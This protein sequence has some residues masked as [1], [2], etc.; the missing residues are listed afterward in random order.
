MATWII[1]T[2]VI[3]AM[4]LAGYKAYKRHKEGGCSGCSGCPRSG[5]CHK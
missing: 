4:V 3:G 2:I 5:E 1:G